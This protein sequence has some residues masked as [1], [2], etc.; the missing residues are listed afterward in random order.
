MSKPNEARLNAA[1]KDDLAERLDETAINDEGVDWWASS[2]LRAA[3]DRI[4]LDAA[5]IEKYGALMAAVKAY[6]GANPG[7]DIF[8][9]Q[10][11]IVDA[12]GA[13][14]ALDEKDKE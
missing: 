9:R 7:D 10:D 3:A 8:A 11:A 12:Y 2:L 13:L 1:D 5:R 14:L 4:R 6:I